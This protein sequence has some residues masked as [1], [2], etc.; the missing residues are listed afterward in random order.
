[1]VP[2]F[3]EEEWEEIS[4]EIPTEDEA[5]LQNYLAGRK[6]LIDEEGKKR[7]GKLTKYRLKTHS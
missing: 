4:Q 6:S 5:V 1:M 7:S 3:T 2:C